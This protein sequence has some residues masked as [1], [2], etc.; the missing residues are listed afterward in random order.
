M[1]SK[2]VDE[3]KKILLT[4]IWGS[5]IHI[6]PERALKGLSASVARK[7]PKGGGHSCWELVYHMQLWQ[8]LTL[9]FIQGKPTEWPKEDDEVWK[10]PK[11]AQDDK[12]WNKLVKRFKEGLKE[13]EDLIDTCDMV[14]QI[15]G[16]E[17]VTI[18]QAIHILAQ[19]NAYHL[20]QLI[21]VRH[22]LGV[23]PPKEK[24]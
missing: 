9:R 14:K 15:P 22:A 6:H 3:I 24:T 20:G 19:H 5:H 18:P 10:I 1:E 8:D 12:A 21:A 7:I 17:G 23:P 16:W 2:L 4:A 13:M 11:D